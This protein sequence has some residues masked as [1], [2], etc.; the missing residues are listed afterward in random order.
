[1]SDSAFLTFI[2]GEPWMLFVVR[3]DH[4]ATVWSEHSSRLLDGLRTARALLGF[5]GLQRDEDRLDELL[6]WAGN[7]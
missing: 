7:V 2:P 3:L 6:P 1:M 4:A 5:A